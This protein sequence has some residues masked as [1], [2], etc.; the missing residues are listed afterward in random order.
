MICIVGIIRTL[1]KITNASILCQLS[2]TSMNLEMNSVLQLYTGSPIDCKMWRGLRIIYFKLKGRIHFHSSF[3]Y[4][5]A[6]DWVHNISKTEGIIVST[7]ENQV[8]QNYSNSIRAIF[9]NLILPAFLYFFLELKIG[10]FIIEI[11]K[12]TVPLCNMRIVK[13]SNLLG[14]ANRC[15][16]FLTPYILQKSDYFR[17]YSSKYVLILKIPITLH[18]FR[19]L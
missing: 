4:C 15:C 2:P 9:S 11:N 8:Q 18:Y 17:E 14:N 16:I 1:L 10:I 7:S 5:Q 12:S 3:L 13:S 19:Y 6:Q